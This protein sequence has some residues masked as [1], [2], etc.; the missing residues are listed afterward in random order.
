[1][2]SRELRLPGVRRGELV[3]FTCGR[4]P[5]EAFEGESVAA[6]LLASG[7]RT[8]EVSP[9]RGEPRG[10]FCAMGA[11]FDCTLTIDG[12]T[13]ERACTTPVREGMVVEGGPWGGA[14][15]G[16]ADVGPS[17]DEE[18]AAPAPE[19]GASDRALTDQEPTHQPPTE[20]ELLVVGAGPGGLCAAIA[21]ARAGTQA[22]VIDDNPRP[23][24]QIYRQ[25]PTSFGQGGDAP[26]GTTVQAGRKLLDEAQAAGVEIRSD[27]T[28]WGTFEP[29]ILEVATRGSPHRIRAKRLVLAAGAHDRPVPLPG[30][31]LPGVFTV[32]GAQALLKSQGMLVGRRVLVAGVGPLLLVVAAQLA[33]AGAE[34]V[35]VVEPVSSLRIAR[36]LPA[37]LR[38]LP[39]A[40]E[41]LGYRWSLAKRRVRW[42]GRS[43]LARIE[44][45]GKVERAVVAKVDSDWCRLPD[46]TQ[47]YEVDAVCLGYGLVPAI[48]L[49][50]ICGC[51]IRLDPQ[52]R[53]W[54][55]A[56]GGDLRS[57]APG[58][59]VVGD[60]AGI[61]GA[62]A[63]AVEGRIAGLTVARE[64]GH[65]AP[66]GADALLGPLLARRAELERFARALHRAYRLRP[67][68]LSLA[69]GD[70]TV[71]RCEEVSLAEVDQA[72]AGGA[73]TLGL[74]RAWT[75]VGMGS[76]Q[77]RMCGS[78][79]M[80]RLASR[81]RRP[82]EEVGRFGA[83]APLK[84]VISLESVSRQ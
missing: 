40:R 20:A 44:G 57:G 26:W 28:A 65:L 9:R 52:T 55:P 37:L 66:A 39:L 29:G 2:P 45:D 83:R 35:A 72:I 42:R 38:E 43:V 31:T 62:R 82:L 71:C 21:A 3:R 13:G 68:L 53:T 47:T 67:G 59:F 27:V 6:A 33:E 12:R 74:L 51:P 54:V 22:L 70:T 75:R 19:V 73:D 79:L 32:G 60:G 81:L 18:T 1:M 50:A 11:C 34:I 48:E 76:C 25:R 7:R 8:L 14:M 63:A 17:G 41:G 49:P 30:W 46:S 64:L 15:A 10:L 36:L 69:E 16:P 58:V 56:L 78:F 61:S 23:G 80:E 5:V 84:P 4:E 24:G 77:G